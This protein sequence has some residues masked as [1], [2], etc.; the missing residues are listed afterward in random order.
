MH[1]ARTSPSGNDFEGDGSQQ[2][3]WATLMRNVTRIPEDTE[4][5]YAPG[6]FPE[7]RGDVYSSYGSR[8][9]IAPHVTIR[10]ATWR[11][12][13]L[14]GPTA[15]NAFTLFRQDLSNAETDLEICGLVLQN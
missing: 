11:G 12:T 4:V 5:I 8:P 6:V 9:Q 2:R 1:R 15:G 13:T 7:L 3:P 10:S 14:R